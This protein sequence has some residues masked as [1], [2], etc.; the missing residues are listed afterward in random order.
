MCR[1]EQ[2]ADLFNYAMPLIRYD[3]GDLAIA[4]AYD[5]NSG[6]QFKEI[7]GRK[8]DV[9]YNTDGELVIPHTFLHIE[10][11]SKCVQFQ[12]IQDDKKTVTN[13]QV[14]NQEKI[15]KNHAQNYL[16]VYVPLGKFY[17]T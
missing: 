10:N 13:E 6:Y 12:F 16:Q 9:I 8:F 17:S 1:Y 15:I 11:Y 2:A 5:E 3:T 14:P 4:A 7:L